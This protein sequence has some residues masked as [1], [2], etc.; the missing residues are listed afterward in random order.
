M[1]NLSLLFRKFS[2][3]NIQLSNRIVMAPMTRS[4]SPNH[5]PTSQVAEYY[6]RRAAHGVGLIITEGTCIDHPAAN[7]YA[8]VPFMFGYKALSGWQKVVDAVHAEGGKIIPQLWHVG[9]TRRAG[10]EPLSTVPAYS[11]SGL[12]ASGRYSGRAMTQ[13]DIQDVIDSFR[14]AAYNAREIGFDGV[15]LHGAHGYL[16]DQFFWRDTNHRDDR[17]GGSIKQR[18]RFAREIIQAIRRDLGNNFLIVLRW[19]QWKIQSFEAKLVESPDELRTFLHPLVQAG[20]D[21]FHCSTRRFWEPAFPGSDLSLAGWTRRVSG[22]PTIA[23]GSV[24][25]NRDFLGENKDSNIFTRKDILG[26]LAQR[27][28]NKEF[29]LVAVGR[30]LIADPAWPEKIRAGN[31]EEIKPFDRKSLMVL[32]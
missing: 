30:A 24:D 18:T 26:M 22:L 15:E 11:P 5:I 32:E 1:P 20:V 12:A 25:M 9:A 29:D 27:I 14:R 23:V 3:R 28:Q 31:L 4:F 7:G 6:R 21:I 8:D 13:Q 17:Y 16:I 2:H 10:A 19:S